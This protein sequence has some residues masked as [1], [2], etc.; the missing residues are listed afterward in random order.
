MNF[1]ISNLHDR[2]LVD[3]RRGETLY[4]KRSIGGF[5]RHFF[6]KLVEV[7][8][9]AALIHGKWVSPKHVAEGS[10]NIVHTESFR[11]DKCFLWGRGP[12]DG[13][14]RCHWFSRGKNYSAT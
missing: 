9:G 4:A 13:W 1:E 12:S 2:S 11:A 6:G 14:E 8:V 7:K 3:M 10:D 5:D